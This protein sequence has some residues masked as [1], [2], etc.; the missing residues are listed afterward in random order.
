MNDAD[1]LLRVE[2][3]AVEFPAGNRGRV[4][5]VADVSFDLARGEAL[6]LVGESGCG[7]SSLARAIMQLPRPTSGTVALDGEKLTALDAAN[8]RSLRPRFQMIFQNPAASL[9]PLRTIGRAIE[10]PLR[11]LGRH[12]AAERTR[13]AREMMAAVG[14]DPLQFYERRPSQLSGGQCQRVSIARALMTEPRLLVCDEPVSSL[15]VSIQAQII[16]LLRE[17]QQTRGLSLLFI[18]HDLAIVRH[19]CDRVAVMYLGKLCEVAPV[20]ALF[21]APRHPYSRALLA[22]I[23]RL[24]PKHRPAAS[25]LLPGEP[26]SPMDSIEGCSFRARCPRAREDCAVQQPELCEIGAG[27]L[28]ACHHP[29]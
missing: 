13:L 9:N 11:T 2:N 14:L 5:A 15:D 1:T 27:H 29:S 3:L 12:D 24:D 16:N 6:G 25:D 8:L 7:K 4:R 21:S 26:F 18:S 28:V 17:V 19:L 23:P 22:A 10:A 20:G